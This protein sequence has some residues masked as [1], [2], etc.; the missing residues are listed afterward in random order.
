MQKT[1]NKPQDSPDGDTK[2][3]SL[4][5]LLADKFYTA[6][7]KAAQ[8]GDTKAAHEL[9]KYIKDNLVKSAVL[10]P[11]ELFN[12]G[13]ILIDLELASYLHDALSHI[14]NGESADKAFLLKKKGRGRPQKRENLDR[15]VLFAREM[16]KRIS[17]GMPKTQAS[18][19]IN[20]DLEHKLDSEIYTELGI[21]QSTIE[22]AYDRFKQYYDSD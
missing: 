21:S 17:Q 22:R 7:I 4:L 1:T 10:T 12:S 2:E 14:E 8:D 16:A 3:K 19:E 9:L 6:K 5:E 18:G 15:D 13:V 20:D 11:K